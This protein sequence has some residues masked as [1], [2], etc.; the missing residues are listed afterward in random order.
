[1]EICK[2]SFLSIMELRF[3]LFLRNSR[4]LRNNSSEA[5][6]KS[7]IVNLLCRVEQMFLIG[8]EL[9]S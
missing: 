7:E 8:V 3:N 2:P 4:H 6:R 1:M 9:L 5:V